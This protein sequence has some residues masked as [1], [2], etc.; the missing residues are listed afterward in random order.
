MAPIALI[1]LRLLQGLARARVRRALQRTSPNM[2]RRIVVG[3]TPAGFNDRHSRLILVAGVIVICRIAPRPIRC[4]GWRIP[5]LVSIILLA[6]SVYIAY[7]CKSRRL[8][9]NQE[10]RQTV[11]RALSGG[12]RS[13]RN[14]KVVLLA[15]FGATAGQAVVW[16]GGQFYAL[17]S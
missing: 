4:L 17:F 5:F 9:G 15:L 16:Y 14:L 3:S 11:G 13:V 12:V 7:S 1:T 8:L 2:H 6:V 10:S